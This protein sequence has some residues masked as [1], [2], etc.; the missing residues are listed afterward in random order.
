MIGMRIHYNKIAN[1]INYAQN[2]AEQEVYCKKL[3]KVTVPQSKDCTTCPYYGGVMGGY[4]H[5]CA[6]EDCYP[7]SGGGIV[8][9]EWADR[10]K[11]LLRVSQLIDEGLLKRG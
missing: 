3:H 10:H 7:S 1:N 11:E 9:I 8:T 6:W 2:Q 5:E 4:G